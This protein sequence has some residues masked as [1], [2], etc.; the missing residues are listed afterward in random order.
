MRAT[1]WTGLIFIGLL[2]TGPTPARGAVALEN[3]DANGDW[4]LDISDGIY[5]LGWLYSGGPAPAPI[6]CGIDDPSGENGDTNSDGGIDLSDVIY[7]FGHLY[8]GGPAPVEIGCG[9]GGG[10]V[11]GGAAQ[12]PISEFVAAQGTFCRPDGAGGC[13][14]FVPPLQNFL[15]WRDPAK[16]ISISVDYA[17]I[18]DAWLESQ[19]GGFDLG[20]A[21]SGS[22]TERPLPD[23]RAEV[24]VR[25]HTRNALSW[26]INRTG[27]PPGSAFAVCP[28]LLGHRAPDVL[29]GAEPALGQSLLTVV[30]VNTAPGAPMP[31]LLQISSGRFRL[32]G[33]EF[34]SISIYA[35]ASGELREASGFPE[36]APGSAQVTQVGLFDTGA[37]NRDDDAHPFDGFPA[38][39]I[40][41]GPT[42]S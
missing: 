20:T 16:N 21:T 28:L 35:R 27:C 23:G 3:G 10:G 40:H 22:I 7:L 5:L 32:P 19:A 12:R 42:G 33:Q 6:A 37:G 38:E 2:V 39:H 11:S 25:L 41:F 17:G 13:L 15:G 9:Q 34:H 30:F 4:A 29:A 31:D 8:L 24:H 18:A 26:V 36:G 14:L 1:L